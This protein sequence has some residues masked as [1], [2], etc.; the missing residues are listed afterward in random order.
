MV[1]TEHGCG[2]ADRCS[3]GEGLNRDRL[4][5]QIFCSLP[6]SFSGNETTLMLEGDAAILSPQ[7]DR[8]ML[9]VADGKTE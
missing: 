8:N 7:G 6:F 9:S 5:W 4:S 2:N 3:D 1:V